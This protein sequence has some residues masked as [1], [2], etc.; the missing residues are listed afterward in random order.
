MYTTGVCPD[1]RYVYDAQSPSIKELVHHLK[2]TKP[3]PST[4]EQVMINTVGL[5]PPP[6]LSTFFLGAY[7]TRQ[8]RRSDMSL[9]L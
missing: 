1:Y 3:A 8:R 9:A 5:P 7:T 4:T 2:T 6:P